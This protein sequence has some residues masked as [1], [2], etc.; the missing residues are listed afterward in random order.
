M[1]NRW[2]L[3][4][5][6]VL[7]FALLISGCGGKEPD[8]GTT[9]NSRTEET[10]TEEANT[11]E[12][13]ETDMNEFLT[14]QCTL[15]DLQGHW[16]DVN[17]NTTLDFSGDE[18]TFSDPYRKEK[19]TVYVTETPFKEIRNAAPNND[20]FFI[21]SPLSIVWNDVLKKDTVVL[22][23]G[24]MVLDARGHSYRFVREED[25]EKEKAIQRM[26]PKTCQRR[27]N[28]RRSKALICP[29]NLGRVLLTC[30]R[31]RNGSGGITRSKLKRTAMFTRFVLMRR[32]ILTSSGSIREK[33]PKNSCAVSPGSSKIR[34][35]PKRTAIA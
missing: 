3:C 10:G 30:R 4:L 21:M 19:F 16:V 12:T 24:E 35:S 25:L 33:F 9:E 29:L 14:P 28:R 8:G 34:R 23:A 7:A 11:E 5:A 20:G 26:I 6:A 18:M 17:G 2:L 15:E 32:G 13:E 22:T 1:K 31:T 27:S